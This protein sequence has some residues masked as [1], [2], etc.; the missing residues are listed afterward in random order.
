MKLLWQ[1][2]KDLCLPENQYFQDVLQANLPC[3]SHGSPNRK[4]NESSNFRSVVVVVVFLLILLKR[5]I[6][7]LFLLVHTENFDF[8][9]M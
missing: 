5:L 3:A 4:N 9:N 2:V 7:A 8:M 1:F 6:Y